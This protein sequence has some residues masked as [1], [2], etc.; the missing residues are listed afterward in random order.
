MRGF[1]RRRTLVFAV[2]GLILLILAAGGWHMSEKAAIPVVLEETDGSLR[3]IEV[4]DS[5]YNRYVKPGE[6]LTSVDWI[7]VSRVED[8]EFVLDAKR[9][10][11]VVT[12]TLV[13]RGEPRAERIPLVPF[14]HS[15]YVAAASFAAFLFYLLGL[16]VFYKRP[17]DK[18]A[19]IFHWAAMSTATMIMATWSRY[20]IEPQPLGQFLRIVFSMA[21]VV[22]PVLFL[23]FSLTFPKQKWPHASRFLPLFYVAALTFGT[24]TSVSFL[25]ALHTPQPSIIHNYLD[26]FNASRWFFI[27][28]GLCALAST[29]HSYRAEKEE[30]ERRKLRWIFWGLMVGLIP[31]VAL[32]VIP[33]ILFSYGL[34]AEEVILLFSAIIPVAFAISIVKYHILDIDLILKRSVVYALAT[35]SLLVIYA[36]I[37]GVAAGLVTTVTVEFSI[38]ISGFAAVVVALLFEPVRVRVQRFV[39]KKFFRVQYNFREAQRKFVEE[40]KLCVDVRQLAS[41]IVDRTNEIIPLERIAFFALEQPGNR[42]KLLEHVGYDLL[43]SRT[44]RFEVEKL[45]SRLDQPVGIEGMIES[46]VAFE[47]ADR[48]VFQRWG[49]ALVFPLISEDRS[50]L[51]FLVLGEKKSGSRFAVEDVDLLQ[52][53][54]AQAALMMERIALQQKLLIEHAEAQR[55][56]ELNRLKSYFVSS[57]SH[58]LKTP[59][60]S[61]RM[62]AEMLQRRKKLGTKQTHE[63]LEIIVGES[64]RLSRLISNVLDFAKIERGVKEYQFGEVSLNDIVSHVLRTM[65]YQFKMAKCTV[66]VKLC[67]HETLVRA[68]ADAVAEVVI[69]LLTN[70]IKYSGAKKRISVSTEQADGLVSVRVSDNGIGV[71]QEQFDNIFEPFFR[72]RTGETQRVGGVGLGL[73]I[74]KHVMD[75]HGGKIEVESTPGIGSAF[76]LVFP[77]GGEHSK[78]GDTQ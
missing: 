72:V 2:D 39:D 18:A 9:V 63:S 16:L 20:T 37:V 74:V 23:H 24:H 49:M 30:P 36:A 32:W 77:V 46:G 51:G 65:Q 71:S 43:E 35:G 55:L 59:L 28:V 48:A 8:V 47:A 75:A 21:Y 53:V 78:I 41:L 70:A 22:L 14:Y 38:L 5:A 26:S 13:H 3:C 64:E 56:E 19:V 54:T 15:R 73:A 40:I 4:A 33:Q 57:V 45:R 34:V 62:F 67:R 60:T 42:L 50:A 76:T 52:S 12:C 7:G 66:R 31:F 10:G 17:D 11:E 29:A 25:R 58:D 27:I 6:S 61:I 1:N 68:D 44:V 69:N